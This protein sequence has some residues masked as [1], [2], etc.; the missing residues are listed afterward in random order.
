MVEP[1]V[2]PDVDHELVLYDVVPDLDADL[3]D[4]YV[5]FAAKAVVDKHADVLLY[6]LLLS[7][8]VVELLLG[9]NDPDVRLVDTI[10][11]FC[12]DVVL[13]DVH[14]DVVAHHDQLV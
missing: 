12:S 13:L 8:V 2:A 6:S 14:L 9:K 1:D 4:D 7:D 3:S 11:Y 10:V 5:D